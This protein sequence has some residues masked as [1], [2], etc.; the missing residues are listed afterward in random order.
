MS[1]R[2]GLPL[3]VEVSA[4]NTHDMKTLNKVV[5]GVAPIRART[6]PPR[7]RP[8]KLHGDKGY[9]YPVCRRALRAQRTWRGSVF[10]VRSV[11]RGSSA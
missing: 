6:G 2:Q 11:Q 7:R 1:D 8:R 10:V 5:D 4:A 9:D 3:N